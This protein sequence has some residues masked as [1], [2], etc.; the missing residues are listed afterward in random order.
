MASHDVKSTVHNCNEHF[1]L[2]SSG[3]E[4]EEQSLVLPSVSGLQSCQQTGQVALFGLNPAS[5][6]PSWVLWF[7]GFFFFVGGWLFLGG[8]FWVWIQVSV[9]SLGCLVQGSSAG[10]AGLLAPSCGG[11][12][13][14]LECSF[15]GAIC[16][17]SFQPVDVPVF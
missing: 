13:S 16:W 3:V 11:L 17:D 4:R 2:S 6:L 7:F 1:P 15:R 12:C 9:G 14:G 8:V 5:N 10:M